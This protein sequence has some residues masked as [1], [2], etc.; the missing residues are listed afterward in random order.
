VDGMAMQQEDVYNEDRYV[1]LLV[2]LL[3]YFLIPTLDNLFHVHNPSEF[4]TP[5]SPG[6]MLQNGCSV[7]RG[8]A[9]LNC[10]DING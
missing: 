7:V 5:T 2:L 6:S 3:L 1:L 8:I 9:K 10:L 4:L